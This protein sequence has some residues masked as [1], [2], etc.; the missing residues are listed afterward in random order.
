MSM[1]SKKQVKVC[2]KNVLTI[3]TVKCSKKDTIVFHKNAPKSVRK[4]LGKKCAASCSMFANVREK[5]VKPCNLHSHAHRACA[6]T[7]GKR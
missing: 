3:D 7:T 1:K 4:W 5:S 2:Y 6:K